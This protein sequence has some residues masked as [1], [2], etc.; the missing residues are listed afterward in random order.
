MLAVPRPARALLT[1]L[2]AS[3]AVLTGCLIDAGDSKAARG[4]ELAIQDDAVFVG[5]QYKN[6]RGDKPFDA[7][8]A[9]G[10]TRQRVNLQWAYTLPEAQ[11]NAR[12]KPAGP[13]LQLR[14]ASIS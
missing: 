10:V 8:R 4:M 6:W 3:A 13:E 7:A 5:Q 14:R 11:F 9:L 2:V 12:N 1:A